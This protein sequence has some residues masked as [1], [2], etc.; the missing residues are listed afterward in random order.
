MNIKAFAK[1]W[2]PPALISYLKSLLKYGIYFSGNYP[3]W[4]TC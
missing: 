4:A 3:D 2:L 1:K